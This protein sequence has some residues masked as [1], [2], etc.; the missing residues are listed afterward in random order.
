VYL[1]NGPIQEEQSP[2]N[3]ESHHDQS[4]PILGLKG[5]Q[6]PVQDTQSLLVDV[7]YGSSLAVVLRMLDGRDGFILMGIMVAAPRCDVGRKSRLHTGLL[8]TS[9]LSSQYFGA[10]LP[11]SMRLQEAY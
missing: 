10:D 9:G 8:P 2:N 4:P 5:L 1:R 3:P 11:C 6:V 7:E